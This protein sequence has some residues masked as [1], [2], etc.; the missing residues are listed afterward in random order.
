MA[1]GTTKEIVP[2][3][4]LPS[5]VHGVE[6]G[7]AMPCGGRVTDN[8]LNRMRK[9]VGEADRDNFVRDCKDLVKIKH[10]AID[11]VDI[12]SEY[13]AAKY[14][15]EACEK[16]AQETVAAMKAQNIPVYVSSEF[17][18]KAQEYFAKAAWDT[19]VV[20]KMS[21]G[22]LVALS[23]FTETLEQMP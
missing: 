9:L 3:H 21:Q 6:Y 1:A 10:V 20:P 17:D 19:L 11:R 15:K 2:V 13:F 16:I 14:G 18:S 5:S 22:E 4:M 23:A 8:E 7:D 12:S